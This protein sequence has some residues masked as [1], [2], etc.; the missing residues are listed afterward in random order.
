MW[1]VLVFVVSNKVSIVTVDVN[2]HVFV[3]EVRIGDSP[4]PVSAYYN[5]FASVST[6]PNGSA[7]VYVDRMSDLSLVTGT[8][9]DSP[10]LAPVSIES[11]TFLIN[12]YHNHF[13]FLGPLPQEY[14]LHLS[15]PVC[16]PNTTVEDGFSIP[17]Q[18]N[19][20][21][22]YISIGTDKHIISNTSVCGWCTLTVST[23]TLHVWVDCNDVYTGA[24]TILSA[25]KLSLS[26]HRGNELCFYLPDPIPASNTTAAAAL[27]ILLVIL[28]VW[29]DWTQ[30]LYPRYLD[31]D[32]DQ[33]W[34]LLSVV[35]Y[36]LAC[37]I[38]VV[39]IN[40]AIFAVVADNHGFYTMTAERMLPHEDL[41]DLV[42]AYMCVAIVTGLFSLFC[43]TLGNVFYNDTKP[44]PT[45]V[46]SWGVSYLH[47]QPLW[48]RGFATIVICGV[49]FGAIVGI[50]WYGLQDHTATYG[51]LATSVIVVSHLSSPSII[52]DQIRKR[53]YLQDYNGVF[54]IALRW[55][56]QFLIFT[57]IQY[58][59]P[60]EMSGVLNVQFSATCSL[61]VGFILLYTTGR[62]SAHILVLTRRKRNGLALA[63][64]FICV[65]L[66]VAF[67]IWYTA[68]F[69][70]GGCLFANGEAL[71]NKGD[72]ALRCGL[73]LSSVGFSTSFGKHVRLARRD[74]AQV[75]TGREE[76]PGL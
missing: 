62:D 45:K 18:A 28:C 49:V 24:N 20:V 30:H 51:T 2:E 42:Y 48:Y 76:P 19:N 65:Y 71:N 15:P 57:T 3:G 72:L 10:V 12:F 11:I 9:G 74:P 73:T 29:T 52:S 66:L 53:P 50:W 1:W 43:L 22:S 44:D 40:A 7:Y 46:F 70:F 17:V 61:I 23:A 26:V 31:G 67:V 36:V 75:P 27:G 56:V 63:S 8:P 64:V 54:L 59:I 60:F 39:L 58:N 33:L 5:P 68:V 34:K 55:C 21:S 14:R 69:S 37:D 16:T 6:V 47:T 41:R 13:V 4:K 38:V 35:Y 25:T 32:V